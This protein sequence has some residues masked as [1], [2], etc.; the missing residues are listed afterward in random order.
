VSVPKSSPLV[1]LRSAQIA[2]V[3]V[4]ANIVSG[5]AVRLSDSGLG[6]PDW[7]SCT[8]R[9]L[10][11]PLALHPAIEFGNRMVVVALVIAAG[12]C[13][14]FTMTRAPRR[15]DLT[16]LA[17]GLV[18]GVVGEAV[19]GGIVV[20]TK[21]N[22]YAVMTHF[23][24]GIAVLSDATALALRAG[25]GRGLS[26]A[27]VRRPEVR[28]ARVMVVVLGFVI[29]AGSATTGAGPHAGGKGAKRIP[30]TLD[31]VTRV[32]SG[33]VWVLVALTLLM[34]YHLHRSDVPDEVQQRG[35]MLLWAMF[36]Q[37]LIGYT[38]FFSHLPPL[39]VGIHVAGAALV[40]MSMLWFYSGLFVH[41]EEQRPVPTYAGRVRVGLRPGA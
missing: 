25:R 27:R 38:Q 33:M 16:L 15:R 39:L 18:A 14:W 36:A 1:V 28:L 22:A 40:W 3:L 9:H 30:V 11:P 32:H 8:Q 24:L 6:C 12:A 34:L 10:T 26:R 7:P 21:L 2:L 35:R 17:W 19:L 5:A 37:G 29:V 41:P 4:V 23:C 13:V 20:Y 31:D